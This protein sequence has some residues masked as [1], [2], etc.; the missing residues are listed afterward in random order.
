MVVQWFP[1]T[2]TDE[3]ADENAN[4]RIGCRVILDVHG[5][6]DASID[7]SFGDWAASPSFVASGAS[8]VS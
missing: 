7:S 6:V 3:N 2:S 5:L 1:E 8:V 4:D